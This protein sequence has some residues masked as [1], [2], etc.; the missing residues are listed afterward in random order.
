MLLNDLFPTA[1]PSARSI[2][3][4]D[5]CEDSRTARPGSLFFAHRGTRDHGLHH[6]PQA[7][8]R[9]ALAA[10][11]PTDTPD[12]TSSPVPLIRIADT[13]LALA[14]CAARM[15]GPL[16]QTILAV[17]GTSGKTSTTFFA[18][19]FFNR[20]HRPAVSIGTI[21]TYGAVT[22]DDAALTTPTA[23][24]LFQ[25]LA[26]LKRQK[27][28]VACLETSSQGLDQKRV[29]TL[30]FT[31]A[32][33]TNLSRDHLN[34]HGTLDAYFA[35]KAR[36]FTEL[37]PKDA[38]AIIY[39]DDPWG[40]KLADMLAATHHPMI[41]IG[42]SPKATWHITC[43]DI[44]PRGQKVK[45]KIDGQTYTIQTSLAGGYQMAN[46]L[47]AIALGYAGGLNLE[48]MMADAG[49]IT[50]PPGRLQ[51]LPG[52][53]RGAAVYV[54][55][56][57]K[58]DALELVL[59]ALA[60]MKPNRLITVFG[61]GGDRDRGKRPLMG[62]IATRLSTDVI[63]TDD[64][65]RSE[66]PATIRAQILASA[67]GAHDIGDRRTAIQTAIHWAGADDIVLIAGKGHELGQK[68]ADHIDPF[69]DAEECAAAIAQLA[70][71]RPTGTSE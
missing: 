52:H 55:Y 50:P 6:I 66:D 22:N 12:D 32:A 9:G 25:Q 23:P 70:Q 37:L 5:L 39:I 51:F 28:D 46:L 59:S 15:A 67:P 26:A 16:P 42:R 69:N 7:A 4:I 29:D 43:H 54:D 1:P 30:N 31:A 71:P 21:G 18:Q 8:E 56:A 38:P 58:P 3:I 49:D 24:E 34:Y 11:V 35:A 62:E 53:P 68:F 10:V 33:F 61:C 17:T 48:G 19:Q 27:I 44:T 47:V 57:H 64:N 41:T 63:I 65:P 2:D 40:Q 14:Q 20:A 36:L 45:I 13:R 60:A